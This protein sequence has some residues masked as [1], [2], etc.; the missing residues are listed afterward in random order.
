M[1]AGA[2]SVVVA[3]GTMEIVVEI[4]LAGWRVI[5]MERRGD[6]DDDGGSSCR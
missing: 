6:G 1:G 4:V 2:A 5:A 3:I